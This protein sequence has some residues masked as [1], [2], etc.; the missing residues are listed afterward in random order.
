MKLSAYAKQIGVTYH[1]AYKMFKRGELDAYQ[2]PSG[3]IIVRQSDE[4]E[5]TKGQIVLYATVK[6][7]SGSDESDLARR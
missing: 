5:P 2:L 3:I 6:K 1:T 7:S 4:S